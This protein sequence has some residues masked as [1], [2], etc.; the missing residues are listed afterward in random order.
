MVL[1][2][3]RVLL[4][5]DD[6]ILM[7]ALQD[8]MTGFGCVVAGTAMTVGQGLA[9]AR[10]LALDLAVLDI[11]LRGELVTPVAEALVE[12]G[13]PFI[14]ASGYDA[15]LVATLAD[16]PRVAKPY[17]K[18]QIFDALCGVAAAP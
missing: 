1:Q 11:N 15:A 16:R 2:G 5:E 4:V 9:L 8:M 12:R 10:D 7:M 13:V 6:V 17:R 14:F 18:Q 3:R